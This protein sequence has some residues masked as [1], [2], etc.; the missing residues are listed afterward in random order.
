VARH[1]EAGY[2]IA[3]ATAA[4]EGIRLPMREG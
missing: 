2:D 3:I 4:R 1:A